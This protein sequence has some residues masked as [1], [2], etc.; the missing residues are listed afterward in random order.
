MKG[1]NYE[2]FGTVAA[3]PGGVRS[4]ENLN[5]SFEHLIAEMKTYRT[6]KLQQA[7]LQKKNSDVLEREQQL[8]KRN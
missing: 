7:Q 1:N 3:D 8:K 2:I 4:G 5:A 6:F